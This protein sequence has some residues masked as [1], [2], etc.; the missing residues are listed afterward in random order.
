MLER[1][2][3]AVLVSAQAIGYAKREAALYRAGSALEI[4]KHPQA[5]ALIL[6][7]EGAASIAR[8]AKRAD[9]ML[10]KLDKAGVRLIARGEKGYPDRLAAAPRAPHL[11]YVRGGEIND[12][13]VVGIVGTRRAS[14]YGLRHTRRI[15]AELAEAGVCVVSGLATG[16]DAAAHEGAIDVRGRTIAV[17][18]SAHD[19]FYPAANRELLDRILACGGSVV[20]EYPMGTPAGRYTFLQRNRIIAGLSQGVL[21]TE[22]ARRSGALST[23]NHAL[24]AGRDV[25]A[26]PGD[27]D[28]VSAQLPN[29]LIA[30]GAAPVSC[31]ADILLHLQ[32][33][34][35]KK[36]KPAKKR[37][38]AGKPAA[39]APVPAE[40]PQAAQELTGPEKMIAGLLLERDMDFDMLCERTGIASDDLGAILMMMELD[41]VIEALPGLKYRHA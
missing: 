26:L 16:I 11:L 30:E 5:Y 4:V 7:Q 3:M 36:E 34:Y 35:E 1:E 6:G 32:G 22:G 40:K 41:G 29:M 17:L 13:Q 18:G 8:S 25:F 15:A 10:E 23:A 12:L 28:R 14:A 21:V 9:A 20:S 19:R 24:D 2:A 31:G 37:R 39:A 38:E 27:I 33:G